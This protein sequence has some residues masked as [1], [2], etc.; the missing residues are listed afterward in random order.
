MYTYAQLKAMF[1]EMMD[2]YTDI[3]NGDRKYVKRYQTLRKLFERR[4]KLVNR[5]LI[6]S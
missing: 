2:H 5:F 4:P 3:T 6:E 1:N